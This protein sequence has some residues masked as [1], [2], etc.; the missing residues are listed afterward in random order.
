MHASRRPFL[1]ENLEP[2]KLMAVVAGVEPN[3]QRNQALPAEVSSAEGLRL[4]G[5]VDKRDR[6]FFVVSFKDAG[7]YQ[8]NSNA[9]TIKV[10]IEDALGNKRLETEPKD[11]MTAAA[12]NVNAGEKLW[13]RVRGINKSTTDYEVALTAKTTSSANVTPTPAVMATDTVMT[14]WL[15]TSG[16]DDVTSLDALLVINHLNR[17]GSGHGDDDPVAYDSNDDGYVSPIDALY[18]I[19]HLN[20]QQRMDVRQEDRRE[21][22][23]EDRQEDRQEDRREDRQQDRRE[24]RA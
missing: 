19:N 10:D 24:D 8:L 1:V 23:R 13:V 12:L 20:N 4:T 17:S 2:R 15:D 11:G 22:R 9:T 21:D 14:D 18:V 6:D 3:D 16:D 7:A 5:A